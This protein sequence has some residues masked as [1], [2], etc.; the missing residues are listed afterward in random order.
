MPLYNLGFSDNDDSS[1]RIHITSR[2]PVNSKTIKLLTFTPPLGDF[3]D[4]MFVIAYWF[5]NPHYPR[6]QVFYLLDMPVICCLR[7]RD[8]NRPARSSRVNVSTLRRLIRKLE[9]SIGP[10]RS[11]SNH[12]PELVVSVVEKTIQD[13]ETIVQLVDH[14]HMFQT[15]DVELK[16]ILIKKMEGNK[17]IQCSD[18]QRNLYKS[19]VEAYESDKI[20]L[21]TYRETV[22]LKRRRDDDA[23]KDEEPSVGLDR[24]FERRR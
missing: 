18:E 10:A 23:D 4:G 17:Y 11:Y 6:H 24:G 15:L 22:M 12:D 20:I 3:P 8:R 13:A 16:K 9:K 7:L 5:Y 14:Q 2:L 1:L 21:D 19:L